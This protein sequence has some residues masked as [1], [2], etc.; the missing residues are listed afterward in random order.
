MAL[1]LSWTPEAVDSLEEIFNY[2]ELE[3]GHASAQKFAALV[4]RVLEQLVQY[5]NMFP[6]A[7][8]HH[9]R[10]GVIGKHTTVYYRID[11]DLIELLLFW[12][13]RKFNNLNP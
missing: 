4:S 11:G 6:S 3:F 9:V 7:S 10:R 5:P 1:R 8:T 2:I 12:N 13:N